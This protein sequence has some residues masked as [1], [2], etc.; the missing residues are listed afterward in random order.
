MLRPALLFALLA[1]P[2]WATSTFPTTIQSHLKLSASPP[3][4][5]GLCHKNNQIG[6][7]TVTTPIGASLR[8]RGLVLNDEA[9]LT[10]A[11]DQLAADK[12][13]SDGDGVG[14]ID[15]L[16]ARTNPNVAESVADGGMG[17][18]QVPPVRYG[19]GANS[20]PELLGLLGAALAL[21]LRRRR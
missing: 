7:G 12:V 15:E 8:A 17:E 11:L 13:D 1:A 6:T 14:D 3:Q 21:G 9:S 16:K 19:C 18:E 10:A 4:S 2:A 5:C 20:V